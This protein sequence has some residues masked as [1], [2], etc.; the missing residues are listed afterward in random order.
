MLK[1][2]LEIN[3]NKDDATTNVKMHY[4]KREQLEKA[5]KNENNTCIMVANTIT[6]VLQSMQDKKEK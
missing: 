3:E 5:S 2:T 6:Q 1:I 4:P